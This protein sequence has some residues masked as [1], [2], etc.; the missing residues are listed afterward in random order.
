VEGVFSE[1]MTHFVIGNTLLT[2]ILT[3]LENLSDAGVLSVV[4]GFPNLKCLKL[5]CEKL[6]EEGI[7]HISQ[8]CPKL[9]YL[10]YYTQNKISESTLLKLAQGNFILIFFLLLGC[11]DL[12]KLN[13]QFCEMTDKVMLTFANCKFLGS[14]Y[15]YC[16]N[17]HL[18]PSTYHSIKLASRYL[19]P[20]ALQYVAGALDDIKTYLQQC[21]NFLNFF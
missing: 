12:R 15:Y 6:T 20:D 14:L 7:L 13:L 11:P 17:Y 1:N 2:A 16:P 18:S 21:T 8:K 9:Q 5:S 4:S 10:Y 19:N 3:F